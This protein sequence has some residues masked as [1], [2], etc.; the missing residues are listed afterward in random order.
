VVV[1]TTAN[2][3]L[4]HVKEIE[5]MAGRVIVAGE[6]SP[7]RNSNDAPTRIRPKPIDGV[8]A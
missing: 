6:K 8:G 1:F 4:E 7:G 3:D 5:A 2:P